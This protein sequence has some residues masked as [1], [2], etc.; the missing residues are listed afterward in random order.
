MV[1]VTLTGKGDL[2]SVKLDDS[3]D[4]AGRKGNP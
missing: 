2:K 3:L 1:T 4:Q